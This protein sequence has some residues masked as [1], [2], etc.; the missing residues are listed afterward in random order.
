MLEGQL[1]CMKAEALAF[2]CAMTVETVA[3]NRCAKAF[4]VCTMDAQLVGAACVRCQCHAGKSAF[5]AQ[6]LIVGQRRFAVLKV[7]HLSRTI[8]YVRA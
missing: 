2:L 3:D 7:H 4:G 8:V 6:H 5:M 1:S